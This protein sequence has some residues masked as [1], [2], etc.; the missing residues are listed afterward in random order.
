MRIRIGS[1][2]QSLNVGLEYH[3]STQTIFKV[4]FFQNYVDNMINSLF[5]YQDSDG[6]QYYTYENISE[7]KTQGF[8]FDSM[9]C[10]VSIV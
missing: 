3:V 7:G 6:I 5:L 4:N 2:S 9:F 1:V 8:E 10:S